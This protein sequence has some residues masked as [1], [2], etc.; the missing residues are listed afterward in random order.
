MI[1]RKVMTVQA[2]W[3]VEIE[4]MRR[5]KDTFFASDTDSPITAEEKPHFNGFKYFPPDPKYL[6]KVRLH[7]QKGQNA[8]VMATSKGTDQRFFNV[9]YFEF[10]LDGQKVQLHAYTSAERDDKDLFIPFRDATSGKASYGAAR[11][12]DLPLSSTD[13]Y[14]LDF[15][16]AYN[17]YCAYNDEYVCPLPPKENWLGV[18]IRAGK[19]KYRD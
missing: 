12:L 6:F 14:A 5:E 1:D 19:K 2:D 7:R 11:Y 4:K 3:R 18:E 13:V 10:E 15:N 17:P 16:Y 8:V 9:G